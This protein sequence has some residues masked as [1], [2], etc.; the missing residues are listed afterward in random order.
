M[1]IEDAVP[2]EHDPEAAV[3]GCYF[4]RDVPFKESHWRPPPSH[5]QWERW[6]DPT[7]CER[8]PQSLSAVTKRR[9]HMCPDCAG[10][11]SYMRGQSYRGERLAIQRA[12]AMSNDV[13]DLIASFLPCETCDS[14][15]TRL[16]GFRI[17][18]GY[19][20]YISKALK[21]PQNIFCWRICTMKK[22]LQRFSGILDIGPTDPAVLLLG[23]YER[24]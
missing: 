6:V 1:G 13:R 23:T 2:L 20:D 7:K 11:G 16:Y 18:M 10:S 5:P 4:L 9:N 14:R 19:E 8:Q 22:L 15:G 17:K 21:E 12:H 3:N 24:P